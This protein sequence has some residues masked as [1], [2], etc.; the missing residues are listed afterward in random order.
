MP[1]DAENSRGVYV[2]PFQLVCRKCQH[3]WREN[4]LQMVTFDTYMAH[5]RS[6]HCPACDANYEHLSFVL[7]TSQGT[8]NADAQPVDS[9]A[10]D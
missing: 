10:H 2:T 1:P 9:K 5:M 3:H 7:E 8:T 4:M 6:I